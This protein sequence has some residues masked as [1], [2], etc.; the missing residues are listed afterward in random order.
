VRADARKG[1]IVFSKG[2]V[3]QNQNVAA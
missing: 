3:K 1:S 2:D